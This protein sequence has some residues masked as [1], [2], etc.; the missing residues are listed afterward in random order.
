MPRPRNLPRRSGKTGN[1]DTPPIQRYRAP[2]QLSMP[3]DRAG[4]WFRSRG[5]DWADS[6]RAVEGP[7]PGPAALAGRAGRGR[8]W[9]RTRHAHARKAPTG[10]AAADLVRRVGPRRHRRN[11]FAARPGRPTGPAVR[12]AWYGSGP[13]RWGGQ[14]PLAGRRGLRSCSHRLVN[15]LSLG[16]R[17]P[18]APEPVGGAVSR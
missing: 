14:L 10:A 8:Q 1:Q 3:A 4:G 18:P 2:D 13:D 7:W 11:G 6:M 16:R 9:R 12:H 15:V 5:R 17:T